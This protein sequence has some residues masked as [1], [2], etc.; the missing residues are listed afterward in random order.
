[1]VVFTKVDWSIAFE[2]ASL[3]YDTP[4]VKQSYGAPC[5]NI[6]NLDNKYELS[7]IVVRNDALENKI[8]MFFSYPKEK[9]SFFGLIKKEVTDGMS[10]LLKNEKN[11]LQIIEAFG[12]KNY[13]FIETFDEHKHLR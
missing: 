4:E 3:I 6:M 1:M 13:G 11:A 2:K 12:R 9:T 7:F 10:A 8:L 5:F